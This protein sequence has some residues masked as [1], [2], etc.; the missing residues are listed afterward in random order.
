MKY[1]I[2]FLFVHFWGNLLLAQV[3]IAP[4]SLLKDAHQITIFDRT[5]FTILD[6]ENSI[7]KHHYKI[8]I[9][10]RFAEAG[11]EIDLYYDN[12][13]T[14]KSANVVLTDAYG[15]RLNEFSIKDFEDWTAIDANLAS[16]SRSKFLKVIHNVYPYFVEVSY[17]ITEKGSL[18]FPTWMPIQTLNHSVLSA[19][20]AIKSPKKEDVRY[21]SYHAGEPIVSIESGQT[22][23]SWK[24][25]NL[26]ILKMEDFAP[27]LLAG[28]PI[29]FTAPNAFEMSGYKGNMNTWEGLGKWQSLLNKDRNDLS[30]AELERFKAMTK[31]CV[32]DED[33][34][35]EVYKYLQSNFR[36]VSIQLGIGGWQPFPT[37][38]VHQK[39]YGDCKALTF[40][41]KS[42]LEHLGIPAYYTLIRAGDDEPEIPKDFPIRMFN[43]AFLTVPLA[44][45]T[46]FLEC[47]SSSD[48]F[49]YL[50]YF[51]SDRNALL[52]K[53]SGGELI[54]TKAYSAEENLKLS[55]VDVIL[56]SNGDATAEVNIEMHCLE[57]SDH[58]N[59]MLKSNKD[60]QK[61]W[62]YDN[63][64]FGDFNIKD[65]VTQPLTNE[66]LP[67]TELFLNLEFNKLAKLTG[68]RLFF[69]PFSFNN[70]NDIKLP[71]ESRKNPIEVKFPF[72]HI[73]TICVS[74]PSGFT[75]EGQYKD[76]SIDSKFGNYTRVFTQ[77]E[78]QQICFIRRLV[79]NKGYYPS[80]EYSDFKNFLGEVQK[81]DRQ[82]VVLIK[83]E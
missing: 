82:K 44:T 7:T 25:E 45:D 47:T 5:N 50:G 57:I 43:H 17:E 54:R 48:P 34:V 32:T 53:P 81:S 60:E 51:T 9:L 58:Y 72:T 33:K 36:Y 42:I 75:I 24:V 49:G 55:K 28:M 31:N 11:R 66:K 4:D 39:K 22:S 70:I 16:D 69:T 18:H 68:N 2:V 41:T 79:L 35:K 52:V 62:L 74:V 63:L 61:K 3:T 29:V 13:S 59:W 30:E 38:D 76:Q 46:I 56:Q 64:E 10:N 1:L 37:A 73:D 12:F 6:A 14:I 26:P 15:R 83:T 77:N 27:H 80:A 21:L 40:Y 65:F 23:I 78:N 8:A 19:E 71:N 67:K 20:F